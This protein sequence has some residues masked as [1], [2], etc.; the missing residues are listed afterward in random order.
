[1][2]GATDRDHIVKEAADVLFFTMAKLAKEGISFSE[3]TDELDFR[4][5]KITRRPGDKKP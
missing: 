1:M 4:S 5:R 2:V 3:V